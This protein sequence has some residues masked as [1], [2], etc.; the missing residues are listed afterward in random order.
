M[1]IAALQAGS[2]VSLM[3]ERKRLG[4]WHGFTFGVFSQKAERG[5]KRG[6]EP[7]HLKSDDLLF[8]SFPVQCSFLPVTFHR[9]AARNGYVEAKLKG[10]VR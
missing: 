10:T 7:D 1:T 2:D 8:L 9:H 6:Q 5:K 3:T 4:D